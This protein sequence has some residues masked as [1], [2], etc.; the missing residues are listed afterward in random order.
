MVSFKEAFD[1]ALGVYRERYLDKCRDLDSPVAS[2][3]D[4]GALNEMSW[5]LVNVFGLAPE[6]VGEL[7]REGFA[8]VPVS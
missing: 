2:R 1:V 3:E 4:Y 8:S 5:V 6:E 7:E